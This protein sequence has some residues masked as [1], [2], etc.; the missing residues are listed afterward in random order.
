MS[1][2]ENTARNCIRYAILLLAGLFHVFL[3]RNDPIA[4]VFSLILLS[5]MIPLFA[6]FFLTRGLGTRGVLFL[7]IVTLGL[8][9][10]TL[11]LL[12]KPFGI[13]GLWSSGVA[14]V[15]VI[16]SWLFLKFY[17]PKT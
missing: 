16:L 10:V 2:Y 13:F 3:L 12:N 14:T 4:D 7:S 15:G 6:Y 11:Y 8:Y 9:M 1:D 5:P 17:Q